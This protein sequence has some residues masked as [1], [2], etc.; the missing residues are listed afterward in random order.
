MEVLKFYIPKQ[1]KS[2]QKILFEIQEI[3]FL[4]EDGP[5]YVYFKKDG[6]PS[7]GNYDLYAEDIWDDGKLVF[8][9][10]LLYILFYK[11]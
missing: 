10:F 1:L 11:Y 5:F 6:I 2:V 8:I 4:K 3:S 9:L 7:S